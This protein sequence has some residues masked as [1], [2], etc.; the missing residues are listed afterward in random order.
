MRKSVSLTLAVVIICATLFLCFSFPAAAESLYIRK[1]VS[2]VY[3]DSGSMTVGGKWA[4]ANY[5]MQSFCGMLNSED[6]LFITY[7]SSAENDSYAPEE[8]DLSSA[9]IQNSVDKIREHT[10]SGMTPYSAVRIA[11]EKLKK[12]SDSNPNTQYWLV[13][14]TDGDFNVFDPEDSYA[15]SN[16]DKTFL[17]NKISD[18]ITTEMPN[19]TFPQVTFFGIG[20]VVSPDEDPAKGVF[21]Y[22]ASD[23]KGIISS[24]SEMADRISGRTRLQ[25]KDIKKIN[26]NTIRVT[27]AIPL[28]NIAVFSQGS[29]AELTGASYA[30]EGSIPISRQVKLSYPGYNNLE[31][32][33][34]LIG[35]S[36]KVIVS[37][38]YDIVFNNKIDL[39]DVVILFEPALELRVTVTLNGNEITDF[40]ELN[41]AVEKDKVSITSKIYEMGTDKQIDS[42]LLPPKTKFEVTV[43]EDG[44]QVKQESGKDL[45]LKEY[46]LKNIPTEISTAV[47][48]EGFNP[49]KRTIK[50]H[51]QEYVKK[52]EYAII[53]SFGSNVRNIKYDDIASNTDMTVCFTITADGEVIKDINQVKALNPVITVSPQG[54][55]GEVSYSN[56]GKIIFT[57]KSA[58]NTSS[59]E[60]SFDVTVTCTIDDGISASEVYTVLLS[61]YEIITSDASN[62]V[63]KTELYGNQE[64]VSFYITKDGVKLGKADVEKN[65][66]ILLNEEQK[67]LKTNMV[68][69]QDGTI[70]VTPYSDEPYNL[71]F[72]SWFINW[73]HYFS[74]K[75]DDIVVTL[76]HSFGTASA[77]VDVVGESVVYILLNV[78]SPMAIEIAVIAFIL[79]WVYA[80]LNKP[81]F[82]L[83]GALYIA[84]LS[85][86]GTKNSRHHEIGNITEISLKQYNKFKYIWK[87]TLKSTEINVGNGIVISAGYGGSIICHSELWYDGDI[88]PIDDI[89]EAKDHPSTIKSYISNGNGFLRIEIISPYDDKGAHAANQCIDHPDPDIYYVHTKMAEI[90][91]IDGV[92]TINTGTIF[93]YAYKLRN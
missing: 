80:I 83:E 53:P 7:M 27:S 40:K 35:D 37:G 54:N 19:G 3:D 87:P 43:I 21:T 12:V 92:E 20:D 47:I 50:F 38:D 10:D 13:I 56:D 51:P 59:G 89:G 68:I 11:F 78:V 14:I 1:I 66:S 41:N 9:N 33:A 29:S 4:Y 30:N 86:G 44:K 75:G 6:Q 42:S 46:E 15:Y 39:D 32:G 69:D 25:K 84:L 34:Y 85:F 71:T 36:Q 22:E 62:P 31:G 90:A 26:D 5:A 65:I 93:S 55:S 67:D 63:K 73:W 82:E 79:W 76:N 77:T 23:A 88:T 72:W 81:K 24:M 28:L 57:P 60:G 8:I 17:N 58:G 74:L 45:S 61:S 52:T 48:I 2:I 18:Y 49:I 70:K 16:Y 64:S 91:L